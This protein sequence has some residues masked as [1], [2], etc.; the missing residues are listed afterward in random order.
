MYAPRLEGPKAVY[1]DDAPPPQEMFKVKLPRAEATESCSGGY[2][3]FPA[4]AF[5]RTSHQDYGRRFGELA[6]LCPWEKHPWNTPTEG[7]TVPAACRGSGWP[8]GIPAAHYS[9]GLW[10][11]KQSSHQ[12]RGLTEHVRVPETWKLGYR[13]GPGDG[14]SNLL[15]PA[16]KA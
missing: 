4:T 7:L 3:G 5:I 6:G 9:S 14:F 11:G 10:N 2:G 8:W 16:A 12:L 15:G 13:I 1:D